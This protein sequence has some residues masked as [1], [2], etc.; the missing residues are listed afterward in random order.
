MT[1]KPQEIDYFKG[2]VTHPNSISVGPGTFRDIKNGW[3]LRDG[4]VDKRPGFDYGTAPKKAPGFLSQFTGL[5]SIGS[6]TFVRQQNTLGELFQSSFLGITGADTTD[7]YKVTAITQI[8]ATANGGTIAAAKNLDSDAI[9]TQ[10][11]ISV[12]NAATG[13]LVGQYADTASI[14]HPLVNGMCSVNG[15]LYFS[16]VDTNKIYKITAFSG[17]LSATIVA[18][19]GSTGFSTGST[20]TS[21]ALGPIRGL[22]GFTSAGHDHIIACVS[23]GVLDLDLTANTSTLVAGSASSGYTNATGGSARFNTP[24]GIGNF[25]NST[26]TFYVADTTNNAIRQIASGVVTTFAGSASGTPGHANG[27][28]TAATFN[29]PMGITCLDPISGSNNSRT[30]YVADTANYEIRAITTGA[31]VSSVAGTFVQLNYVDGL[32]AYFRVPQGL[33]VLQD[34]PGFTTASSDALKILVAD[35]GNSRI[36]SVDTSAYSTLTST[37]AGT[38]NGIVSVN[39]ATPNYYQ[40]NGY[41]GFAGGVMPC[42]T[43]IGEYGFNAFELNNQT[44]INTDRGVVSGDLSSSFSTSNQLLLAGAPQGLDLTLT[45]VGAPGTLLPADYNVGYRLIWGRKTSNGATVLGAPSSLMI[46]DNP[47][48]AGAVKN[49][50][51]VSQIPSGVDATWS[52]QLYRTLVNFQNTPSG[53]PVPPGD[54]EFLCFESSPTAAN[55]QSGT[56]TITDNTPDSLLGAAAYTNA[57][58]ETLSQANTQP[59]VCM[60]MCLFNGMAI[61]ANTIQPQQMFVTLVGTSGFVNGSTIV[62]SSGFTLTANDTAESSATGTFKFFT[63]GTAATNVEDTA[64]SIVRIIN[65][66]TANRDFKAYYI[67]AFNDAPGQIVLRGVFADSAQWSITSSSDISSMFS[68]PLPAS[69]ITTYISSGETLPNGVYISKIDQPGA[70]PLVNQEIVGTS[71]ES[72]RRVVPLRTSCIIIKERSVWRMIGT[73]PEALTITLLDNTVSLRSDH[74][75]SLLN[76]EVYALTTQGVVAISDNGVRIISRDIEYQLTQAT[77]QLQHS[78]DLVNCAWGYGSDD[79]RAYFLTTFQNAEGLTGQGGAATTWVYSPFTNGWTKWDLIVYSLTVTDGRIIAA[80]IDDPNA[81]STNKT[82]N[83]FLIFQNTDVLIQNPMSY[84]D[85]AG[86][87]TVLTIDGNNI[88]LDWTR[89]NQDWYETTFLRSLPGAGWALTTDAGKYYYVLNLNDDDTLA[90]NKVTGLNVSDVV[91]VKRP[92]DFNLR[93]NTFTGGATFNLKQWSDMLLILESKNAYR[94]LMTFAQNLSPEDAPTFSQEKILNQLFNGSASPGLGAELFL[95]Q[96]QRLT[97]PKNG[98]FGNIIEMTF[99]HYEAYSYLVFKA[100]GPE[101]RGVQSTKANQ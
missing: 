98:N 99:D 27:T 24:T 51:I 59:P 45:L 6:T 21:L 28:G 89:S 26:T 83:P 67:S 100:I 25:S 33:C 48:G 20:L 5:K 16:R 72:I 55:L 70:V 73:T 62:F 14:T 47:A 92:I 40:A 80:V 54:T 66:Y 94:F 9:M 35:T 49:V 75:V 31:V 65:T 34:A 29:G 41:I 68:P 3:L 42:P 8:N 43:S 78:M 76:N 88:T 96:T 53:T 58:Q 46:I 50:Q 79:W 77:N 52:Y 2:I 22:C 69:G 95:E 37:W 74:S 86:D 85:Y 13:E 93:F 57:T 38:G 56:I 81:T 30:L 82:L 12:Y 90:M 87:A 97:I 18:G 15:N 39:G 17:I 60:D 71:S 4:I 36:R 19:N 64:Q 1:N 61:Y 44:Y 84:A 63:S 7:C 10:P 23:N 32:T 91:H 101:T 11:F